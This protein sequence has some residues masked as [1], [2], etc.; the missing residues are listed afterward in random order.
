MQSVLQ[1][2][3]FDLDGTLVN[4]DV[5][6]FQIWQALLKE[7]GIDIDRPFYDRH[8]VGHRNEAIVRDVL[9]QMSFEAGMAIAREKEARFR[10]QATQLDR[11]AGLDR[12]LSW[13][14]QGRLTVAVVTNAPRDNAELLLKALQLSDRFDCVVISDELPQGKPHP[15]PYQTALERL[16]V[17]AER[18]I[19]FEDT[20]LGITSAIGAGVVTVGMATTHAPSV[21]TEAGARFCIAD[22]TDPQL[23]QWLDEL[24]LTSPCS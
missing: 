2:I 13:A 21:L 23:W 20:P 16:G 5:Y 9:S 14:N 22:F 17:E 6:H 4:T 10:Q 8:M 3:L 12:L 24:T 19:S 1:A 11:L 18:A 15:L 7:Q